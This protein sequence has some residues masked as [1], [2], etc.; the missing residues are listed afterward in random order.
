MDQPPTETEQLQQWSA[1]DDMNKQIW[2]ELMPILSNLTNNNAFHY[3]QIQN[4]IL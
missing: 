2:P 4:P 1:G 3:N